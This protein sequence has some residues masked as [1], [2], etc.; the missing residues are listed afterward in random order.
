MPRLRK[1]CWNND[2]ISQVH[3]NL[4]S[5]DKEAE[6]VLSWKILHIISLMGSFRKKLTW[7]WRNTIVVK[8]IGCSFRGPGFSSLNPHGSS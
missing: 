7:D 2:A 8:S 1:L 5:T 4:H 6:L 3:L